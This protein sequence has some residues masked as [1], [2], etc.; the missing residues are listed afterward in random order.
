MHGNVS[1]WVWD[2]YGEYDLTNNVNN[3]LGTIQPIKA[4]AKLAPDAVMGEPLSIHY[5]GGST[6]S[7][8]IAEWRA[9]NGL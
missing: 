5:G 4:I 9:K 6:L 8:D 1:E 2:Y 7:S 3:E